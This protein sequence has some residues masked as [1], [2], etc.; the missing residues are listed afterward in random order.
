MKIANSVN[1]FGT[2]S[3]LNFGRKHAE[4]LGQSDV[5]AIAALKQPIA[6]AVME[7]EQSYAAR[8]PL[9]ALWNSAT[10]VKDEADEALDNVISELSYELL[11]PAILKGNRGAPSY[12]ALFPE[13]NIGFINGPDRAELAQVSAMVAYLKANPE[14]PMSA[15]ATDLEAKAAAL[16]ASLDPIVAAEAALRSAQAA[17]RG[18]R[19]ALVRILRKSVA[20]IRAELMDEKK[21]QGL[22]PTVQEARIQ[23]DEQAPIAVQLQPTA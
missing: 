19:E 23:E 22:F 13:G 5:P 9:A 18:K 12:R 3:L 8:R 10:E 15:R 20:M 1:K 6:A 4:K 2:L 17:E 11:G 21:V 7:L 16:Q 14:H